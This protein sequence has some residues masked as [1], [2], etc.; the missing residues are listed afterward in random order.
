M[1]P[2]SFLFAVAMIVAGCASVPATNPNADY[3]EKRAEIQR[4]LNEIF[5]AAEKKD[6]TR[7]D[8]Y[9]LYG[10]KFTK[11]GGEQRDRQDAAVA[12][13][14]EHDGLGAVQD[15]KMEADDLKIDV[16]GNVGIAT[17]ILRYRFKAGGDTVERKARSTLVFAEDH[18]TWKIVHEHFSAFEPDRER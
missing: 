17:F 15:L 10:P 7:L 3:P 6:L 14:G 16:F 9:H 4:R 5:D 18:G 11:F 8:G 12:R 13:Q 1:R 2:C